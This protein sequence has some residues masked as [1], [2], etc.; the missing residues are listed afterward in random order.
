MADLGSLGLELE[1]LPRRHGRRPQVNVVVALTTLLGVDDEPGELVW[2]GPITAQTA[3]RIAADGTWRR[4]LVDPRTGRL[5]E[6]SA[7]TYE[8]PQEMRDLVITRD[9]TCRGIGC[10][11]PADRCDLDHRVPYPDGPTSPAN[12]DPACRSWHRI[13]TFTDTT[14]EAD[15]AGGLWI[16]L[17]EQPPSGVEPPDDPDP[18][19]VPP[20]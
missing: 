7:E 18:P 19:D 12:F 20:F 16:T 15:G 2:A 4:L 1:D 10:R 17:V 13:K 5:D 9:R 11:V 14:V 3:R 6:M 8:P